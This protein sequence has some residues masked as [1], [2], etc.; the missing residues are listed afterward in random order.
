M[1]Q[2]CE[3]QKWSPAKAV[4]ISD[5]WQSCDQWLI[6][7]ACRHR[8]S[9]KDFPTCHF[10]FRLPLRSLLCVVCLKKA[11]DQLRRL[12]SDAKSKASPGEGR[13]WHQQWDLSTTFLSWPCSRGLTFLQPCSCDFRNC[14]PRL[15]LGGGGAGPLTSYSSPI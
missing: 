2:S 1:G 3:G 13:F 14:S 11:H 15:H 5:Q 4:L 12:R 8:E 7:F 6:N 10:T 9:L